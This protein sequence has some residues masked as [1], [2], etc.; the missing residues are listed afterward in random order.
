MPWAYAPPVSSGPFFL[1][2]T[3]GLYVIIDH[4]IY[5]Q[6]SRNR[7]HQLVTYKDPGPVLNKAGK[8]KKH[9]PPP[10]QD[11][12]TRFY[13]AQLQLYGLEPVNS[14]K[15]AKKALLAAFQAPGG[16][17]KS[18]EVID[19]HLALSREYRE[20]NKVAE[21]EYKSQKRLER[22]LRK[23][24][25]AEETK[26][27][28]RDEGESGMEVQAPSSKKSKS[29]KVSLRESHYIVLQYSP[30]SASEV[31]MPRYQQAF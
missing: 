17:Y 7:I 28:Q 13:M 23:E 15:A 3:R 21:E 30:C 25:K 18:E 22:S 11:E 8:P 12:S 5:V 10:H 2:L 26:K 31:Q 16:L 4:E 27:R 20:K 6:E 1:H 29:N 24:A 19:I 9:Q 14:K